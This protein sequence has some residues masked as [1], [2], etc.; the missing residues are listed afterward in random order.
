MTDTIDE[1]GP[2]D[3]L[4]VEF[5][6]GTSNFTG[7]MADE[8]AALADAGTIRVLDLLILRKDERRSSR[9]ARD[10]RP[11][12]RSTSCVRLEADIAEIL[13]AEDVDAPRRG[14]G[15]RHRR[16]RPRLGEQLGGAVRLGGAPRGRP[17]GRQ[18]PHPDPGDHR[19]ARGRRGRQQ[20]EP[21]MPL[22]PA[23]A[24]R[25]GVIG[26]PVARTAAVV[27]TAAVVAHGVDRRQD[28]R[29]DRRDDRGDR[30]ETAAADH[31]SRAGEP[32]SPVP[33]A[34]EATSSWNSTCS[35]T[36]R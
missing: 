30:R 21:D 36:V 16:R 11:R 32:A 28:R 33:P 26:R 35:P 10:R 24:A 12:R 31:P 2:V 20:K 18:R 4:V 9:G 6:A 34:W 23:R 29:D 25:R 22:R 8:L 13:A 1:L 7:E 5:P 19:L 27:G 15:A 3:Y 14:D 17:A